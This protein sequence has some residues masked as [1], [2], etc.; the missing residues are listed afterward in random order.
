MRILEF[1][2]RNRSVLCV[3]AETRGSCPGRTGFKMAVPVTGRCMGSIGGGSLEHHVIVMAREMLRERTDKP[4]LHH[5]SH[6]GTAEPEEASGMICSGSQRILLI[7]SPPL[8]QMTNE[9]RG[10]RAT[11]AGLEFLTGTP[12]R[13]GLV[14][15]ENWVY[16]EA[17]RLPHVVYIFG[18]GHCSLALTPLLNSLNMRTVI[19][20]DRQDVW[21]MEENRDAWQRVRMDYRNA[22]DM[23]PD[24]SSALVVIMT[25]SHQG[26][27]VI[28]EQML[29]KDLLYLGMMASRATAGHIMADMREKGFTGEQLNTVHTPIG[30][31]ISSHTPAEIA[32]SIAAEIVK[33]LNSRQQ[34]DRSAAEPA[35]KG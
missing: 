7:P 15:G 31:P 20:D 11:P 21:T 29:G 19:I 3:I 17:V 26:D 8:N 9:L 34:V 30:I 18:G 22:G 4:R 28:L 24:K 10:I 27:A 6:T 23:V 13:E 14:S 32:V 25:A 2:S 33:V 35:A 5:F 1:F 16:T 12:E